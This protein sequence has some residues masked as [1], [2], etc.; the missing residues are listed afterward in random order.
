MWQC[1]IVDPQPGI[2]PV[3]PVLDTQSLTH[4]TTDQKIKKKKVYLLATL[5]GNVGSWI[6]N[7]GLNLRHLYWI[8]RVLPTGPSGKTLRYTVMRKKYLNSEKDLDINTCAR[9]SK[10]KR[11][12]NDKTLPAII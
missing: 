2:E 7:Q 8:L 1:G 6:P 12:P 9:N 3:P 5:C 11:S 4:W 10:L